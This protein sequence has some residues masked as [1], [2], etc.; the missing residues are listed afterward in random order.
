V[1]DAV[2]AAD[3]TEDVSAWSDVRAAVRLVESSSRTATAEAVDAVALTVLAAL[4]VALFE[5]GAALDAELLAVLL[6]AV[7]EPGKLKRPPRS[8]ADKVGAELISTSGMIVPD[9]HKVWC[10]YLAA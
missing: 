2:L 10:A 9:L 4:A 8:G 7:L 5:A 3:P 6:A 1:E